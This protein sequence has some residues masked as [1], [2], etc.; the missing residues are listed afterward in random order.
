MNPP[1]SEGTVVWRLST[2]ERE[3][4]DERAARRR[5]VEKLDGEKA[6]AKDVARLAQEIADLRAQ[7]AAD[8]K[9]NRQT[10]QWFMGIVAAAVLAF[11]AIA[12][13]LIGAG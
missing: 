5:D 12:V 3:L 13:Q 2:L 10:L 4:K 7:T 11:A 9:A 1:D 6:D 8:S